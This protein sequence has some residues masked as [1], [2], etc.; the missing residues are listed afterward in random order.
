MKINKV[1]NHIIHFKDILYNNN[2]TRQKK[3]ISTT[4]I[5]VPITMK[6]VAIYDN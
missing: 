5:L 4:D 6:N 1:Y 3:I 2:I